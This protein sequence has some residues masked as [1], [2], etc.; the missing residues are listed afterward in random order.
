MFSAPFASLATPNFIQTV[1]LPPFFVAATSQEWIVYKN[2]GASNI[3]RGARPSTSRNRRR[4]DSAGIAPRRYAAELSSEDVGRFRRIAS[5]GSAVR[6][7]REYGSP[8]CC[9]S[10]SSQ[11]GSRSAAGGYGTSLL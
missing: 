1:K 11:A 8:P 4:S 10:Y 5:A 2:G 7:P 9:Q 6:R 3:G